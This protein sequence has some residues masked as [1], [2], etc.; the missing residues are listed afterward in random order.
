MTT[1]KQELKRAKVALHLAKK[2][3]AASAAMDNFR[4][5]CIDCGEHWPAADDTRITL[6]GKMT[7]YS[8]WL[9]SVY[10]KKLQELQILEAYAQ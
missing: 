9:E 5:A 8:G 4:Y 3:D 2:L 7:E 6:S 1:T 10:R